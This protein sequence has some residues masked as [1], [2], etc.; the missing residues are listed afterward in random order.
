MMTEARFPDWTSLSP[1]ERRS[2]AAASFRRL[3]ELGPRLNATV[4]IIAPS[5]KP[6]AA[7]LLAGLPYATKDMLDRVG[8]PAGWGGVRADRPAPE[9]T[10]EI[11]ERLDGAG[12]VEVAISAMTELAYEPSGYNALRGRTLNPWHPDAVS[13]GSSSGS[14]ALVACG[15][16]VLGLGSDTGGSVRIPAGCCGITGLKPTGGA[17]LDRAVMPL[18]PSMDAIG[19]MA[20]SAAEIASVLPVVAPAAAADAGEPFTRAAILTDCLAQ[21]TAP[22][23]RAFAAGTEA[24]RAA[25]LEIGAAQLGGTLAEADGHAL[26]VMQ[27]ESARSHDGFGEEHLP[28]T[29]A[30]RLAKGREIADDILEA[31]HGARSRVAEAFLSSLGGAEAALLPVMPIETPLAAETDPASAAFQPRVLY[32]M[33]QFTRFVNFLGLPALSLPCGFDERGVPIGLQ[34]IGPAGS[35]ARLLATA[36]RVQAMTD[37][38]G[39]RPPALGDLP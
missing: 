9:A 26:T 30:R 2:E 28:P 5:R 27:A 31:S 8:R 16:V 39:R 36:I 3:T 32:R 23:R 4:E 37:W 18:A 38:H 11:L 13:G 12:A 14:A 25:G 17:P 34:M 21:A 7:G 19:F 15:A 1:E 20:R 33:S 22:V 24:L 35:E 29:L 10:A 6:E